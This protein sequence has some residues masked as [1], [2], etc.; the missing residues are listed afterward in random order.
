MKLQLVV[1]R[2]GT[3]AGGDLLRNGAVHDEKNGFEKRRLFRP[4]DTK[5]NGLYLI[6]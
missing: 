1:G 6:R 4:E 3:K 5:K 2:G